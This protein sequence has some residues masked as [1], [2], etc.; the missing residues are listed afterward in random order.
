MVQ[1]LH[2]A[3]HHCVSL[4]LSTSSTTLQNT[5]VVECYCRNYSTLSI[6]SNT[7]VYWESKHI[8]LG[9]AIYTEDE[10]N[11]NPLVY[12]TQLD[13]SAKIGECF[14]QLPGQ[15]LSNGIDAQLLFKNNSADAGGVLYMVVQ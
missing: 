7:T 12:C 6:S 2:V 14:F 4:E 13:T 10:D 3:T 11:I 9:G 5:W 15:N 8:W 1:F